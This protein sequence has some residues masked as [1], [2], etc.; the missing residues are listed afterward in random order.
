MFWSFLALKVWTYVVILLQMTCLCALSYCFH[1]RHMIALME[2][3]HEVIN[4]L[5]D[6]RYIKR[7]YHKRIEHAQHESLESGWATSNSWLRSD[8]AATTASSMLAR[9]CTA[10]FFGVVVLLVE[11]MLCATTPGNTIPNQIWNPRS[12]LMFLWC[13]FVPDRVGHIDD[14]WIS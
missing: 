13:K 5:V 9:F 14:I 3:K 12:I 10:I 8:A 4:A 6:S 7:S 2:Q 1:A 11:K